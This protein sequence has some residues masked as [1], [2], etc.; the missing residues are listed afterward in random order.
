MTEQQAV[1]AAWDARDNRAGRKNLESKVSEAG[2]E[3]TYKGTVS[4]GVQ[5]RIRNGLWTIIIRYKIRDNAILVLEEEEKIFHAAPESIYHDCK[6][7][8]VSLQLYRG[9]GN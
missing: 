9:S 8:G 5:Q 6:R 2:R 1:E 7:V 4:C 3:G